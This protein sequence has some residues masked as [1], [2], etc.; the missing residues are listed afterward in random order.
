MNILVI[1]VDY[2]YMKRKERKKKKRK[3]KKNQKKNIYM[4]MK[5]DK[6]LIYE[7]YIPHIFLR[8]GFEKDN[9]S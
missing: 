4:C 5:I 2:T 7:I 1:F 9:I 8:K 3:S 6:L